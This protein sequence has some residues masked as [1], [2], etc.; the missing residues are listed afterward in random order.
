MNKVYGATPLLLPTQAH[1]HTHTVGDRERESGDCGELLSQS[2]G[3]ERGSGG[4]A[5]LGG[6]ES[7]TER[8]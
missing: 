8:A 6:T 2:K 5:S 4:G 3:L 7:A 1:T